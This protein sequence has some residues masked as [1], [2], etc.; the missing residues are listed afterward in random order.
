MTPAERLA[1]IVE[2][3]IARRTDSE[4]IDIDEAMATIATRSA[5][6]FHEWMV[7][8]VCQVCGND[9]GHLAHDP[10]SSSHWIPRHI[11]LKA[12]ER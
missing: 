11:Y 9:S 8:P 5:D 4:I 2:E 7:S 10:N 6:R 3:E 1:Q 12:S